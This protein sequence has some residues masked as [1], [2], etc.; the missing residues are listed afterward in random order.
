MLTLNVLFFILGL[1]AFASPSGRGWTITIAFAGMLLISF[2]LAGYFLDVTRFYLYGLMLSGGF[3][4]GEW[5]YQTFG[6]SHH[7]IPIVFGI[8]TGVIFLTGLFKLITFVQNNPLP[9]DDH[10]QWEG[11]NG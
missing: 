8:S 11:N 2:S 3:I 1:V 10:V 9:T 6:V 5:L 4:V 7:G